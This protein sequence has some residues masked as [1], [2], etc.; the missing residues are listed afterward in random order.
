VSSGKYREKCPPARLLAAERCG[1]AKEQWDTLREKFALRPKKRRLCR[2]ECFAG[3]DPVQFEHAVANVAILGQM[4]GSNGF[5]AAGHHLVERVALGELRVE[6]PAE[7][8]RPAGA[9]VGA[10]NDGWVDVFHGR[11]LLEKART[12]SPAWWGRATTFSAPA[13]LWIVNRRLSWYKP[14]YYKGWD[15]HKPFVA[16]IGLLRT[17]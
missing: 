4:G 16:G 17:D 3:S 8:T 11:R 9:G 7:F 14:F 5:A 6:L 15:P 10:M 1:G 2:G 12:D 13:D